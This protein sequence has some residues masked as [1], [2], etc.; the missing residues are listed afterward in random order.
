[1]RRVS[2]INIDRGLKAFII[3]QTG[4]DTKNT[5]I[6]IRYFRF[7]TFIIKS[8]MVNVKNKEV[9]TIAD[10]AAISMSKRKF[11][12][13]RMRRISKIPMPMGTKAVIIYE[14]GKVARNIPMRIRIVFRCKSDSK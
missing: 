5:T 1:V 10:P 14:I 3:S 12:P 8:H 11:E 7:P 6:G 9:R 13:N 2:A 4:K